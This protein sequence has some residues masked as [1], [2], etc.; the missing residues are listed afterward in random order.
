MEMWKAN[1]ASHIHNPDY[2][3]G[4]IYS[5]PNLNDPKPKN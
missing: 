2:D 5:P 4:G 1:N 3:G